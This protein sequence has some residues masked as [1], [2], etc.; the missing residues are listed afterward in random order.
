MKI[1]LEFFAFQ[2]LHPHQ[3]T[4]R[5]FFGFGFSKFRGFEV[6]GLYFSGLSLS[7]SKRMKGWIAWIIFNIS[8]LFAFKLSIRHV[9]PVFHYS[10]PH[11]LDLIQKIQSER[12]YLSISLR[13]DESLSILK[14]LLHHRCRDCLIGASTV[15]SVELVRYFICLCSS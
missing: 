12:P 8:S 2:L 15:N 4:F 14:E 13:Q 5:S 6:S 9:L 3:R 7:F 10:K 1:C 11:H